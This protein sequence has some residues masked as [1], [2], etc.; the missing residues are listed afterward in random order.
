MLIL[1]HLRDDD[2]FAYLTFFMFYP[3]Q[4]LAQTFNGLLG[5]TMQCVAAL[6]VNAIVL[7]WFILVVLPVGVGYYFLQ[8]Y[9]ITTSR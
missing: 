6:V 2:Q 1:A 9:F 7:P 5:T 3:F 4:R 8:K